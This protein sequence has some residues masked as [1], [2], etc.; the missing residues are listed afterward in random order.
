MMRLK[1]GEARGA[2]GIS[3]PGGTRGHGDGT[4]GQGEIVRR[5]NS[6]GE[7]SRGLRGRAMKNLRPE[8]TSPRPQLLVVLSLGQHLPREIRL[9]MLENIDQKNVT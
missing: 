4:R 3:G 5:V 2:G 6:V 7:D 1:T 8:L 9:K